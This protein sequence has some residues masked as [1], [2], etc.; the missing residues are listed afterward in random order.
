MKE[1]MAT[2]FR[3]IWSDEAAR[4]LQDFVADSDPGIPHVLLS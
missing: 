2:F 3:Q 4:D 1:A